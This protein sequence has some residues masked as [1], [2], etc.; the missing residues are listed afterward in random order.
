[1]LGSVSGD[2][3]GCA[4]RADGCL[5]SVCLPNPTTLIRSAPARIA[6]LTCRFSGLDPLESVS[7]LA[8]LKH[9]LLDAPRE[10]AGI[11]SPE[12]DLGPGL[13]ALAQ[14]QYILDRGPW[15]GRVSAAALRGR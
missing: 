8:L 4:P 6:N 5:L 12:R 11:A 2:S 13:L 15:M 9:D 7:P 14:G 3:A 1:M 10:W